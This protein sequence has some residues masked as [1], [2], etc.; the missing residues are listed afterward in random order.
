MKTISLKHNRVKPVKLFHP[1]VFSGAL[2]KIEPNISPGEI[3]LVVDNQKKFLSYAFYNPHSQISLRNLEWHENTEIN[4]TWWFNKIKA[5]VERRKNLLQSQKTNAFRLIYSESDYLPGLIVDYYNNFL[6]IQILSAGM[7][8]QKE[9][10][11]K[12]LNELL[13]PVGIYER[14]DTGIRELD[15]LSKFKGNLSGTEPPNLIEIKENNL[16]FLID[17]KRGQKTGFYLDQR[18]NRQ[19]ISQYTN[20]LNVLDCFSFSGGFAVYALKGQAK[21][22]T[23]VDSSAPALLQGSE[24]IKKN[25]FSL[26]QS[27]AVEDNIFL[28][29]RKMRD[30]GKIFDMIILDPPKFAP[31]RKD[32]EKASR[33]Y[34]DINVIALKLLPANGLLAT[35]SCS[36]GITAEQFQQVIGWASVDAEKDVQIIHKL[37][38]A[39][40]HPI[41]LSFPESEYLKGLLC[42]VI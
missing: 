1:W 25:N 29:L 35:F 4:D 42:R 14:S 2:D 20:G 41:R 15:G 34:K 37:G 31:T 12:S 10:I 28:Y 13:K 32:V 9:L 7:E 17:I 23:R 27:P 36:S 38:Q 8:K 30:A 11:V 6:V 39:S 18:D 22:V 19:I 40:D 3:V 21:S 5:A 33:A 16:T 26:D 24:N